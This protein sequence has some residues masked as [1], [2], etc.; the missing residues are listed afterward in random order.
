MFLESRASGHGSMGRSPR[1]VLAGAASDW[2]KDIGVLIIVGSRSF[3]D[4]RVELESSGPVNGRS[5]SIIGQFAGT[6]VVDDLESATNSGH[7][8]KLGDSSVCHSRVEELGFVDLFI[9]FSSAWDKIAYEAK[10]ISRYNSLDIS[11]LLQTVLLY[12]S[13]VVD[14]TS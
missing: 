13:A 3:R 11:N 12:Q 10:S 4:R 1:A 14:W 8:I 9:S 2:T 5:E 6:R 7:A